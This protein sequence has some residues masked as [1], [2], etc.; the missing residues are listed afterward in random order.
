VVR[1]AADALGRTRAEIGALNVFPV[2]DADTLV[3]VE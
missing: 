3:G 1:P 2:P